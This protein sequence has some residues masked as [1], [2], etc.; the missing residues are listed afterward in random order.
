MGFARTETKIFAIF[1]W[2]KWNPCCG[3]EA[4]AVHLQVLATHPTAQVLWH[5]GYA[6]F[7]SE[8]DADDK[9]KSVIENP[10]EKKTVENASLRTS[11]QF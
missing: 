6:K 4:I 2:P 7:V 5:V 1:P 11:V 9:T 3:T 8:V 10:Y